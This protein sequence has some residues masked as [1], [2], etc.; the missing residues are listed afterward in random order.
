M[1]MLGSFTISTTS[2]F[3][4]QGAAVCGFLQVTMTMYDSPDIGRPLIAFAKS[5]SRVDV[6]RRLRR[7]ILQNDLPLVKRILD[8]N[9]A[10]LQNPDLSD[11]SNTSLHLAAQKGYVE[12]AVCPLLPMISHDILTNLSG[13]SHLPRP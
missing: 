6:P 13:T 7:A 12:I 10:Y 8:A 1:G 3:F 9:P 11:K 5:R 2:T 4:K